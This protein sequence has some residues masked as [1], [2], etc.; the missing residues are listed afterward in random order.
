MSAL[1]KQLRDK[2]DNIVYP[3]SKASAVYMPNGIDTVE[4][5]LTDSGDYSSEITFKGSTITKTLASGGKSV[6]EFGINKIVETVS[7]ENNAV[8][9]TKTTTFNADGSIK[10]EVV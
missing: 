10:I 6:T 2:D 9:K 8:I 7:N 4:R 5:V 1:V 3:I